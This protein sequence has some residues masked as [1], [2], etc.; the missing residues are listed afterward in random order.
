MANGSVAGQR[1]QAGLVRE[2][3]SQKA[4][5]PPSD[6]VPLVVGND[7]GALLAAVLQGVQTEVGQPGGVGV[8]PDPKDP[9][10]LVDALKLQRHG[11]CPFL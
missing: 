6:Q 5:A 11:R 10:L 9:A 1:R 4:Q 3:L 7:A 2:D 8:A